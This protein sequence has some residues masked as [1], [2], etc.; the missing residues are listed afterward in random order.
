VPE[1]P[2]GALCN[3]RI[4]KSLS[5]NVM[6]WLENAVDYLR[7]PARVPSGKVGIPNSRIRTSSSKFEFTPVDLPDE[8]RKLSNV[9]Q[10]GCGTSCSP[11]RV[12]G[13]KQSNSS[14]NETPSNT[15]EAQNE[16][17]NIIYA[18]GRCNDNQ[19]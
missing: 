9:L 8:T 19:Q 16:E 3:L 18:S 13:V 10:S 7:L 12:L 5:K 11:K 2:Y 17:D 15:G 4:G 6:Q 1:V 14:R